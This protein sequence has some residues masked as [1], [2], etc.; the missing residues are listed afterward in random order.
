MGRHV[1]KGG[2][3]CKCLFY[4]GGAIRT[5]RSEPVLITYDRAK[6]SLSKQRDQ[7]QCGTLWFGRGLLKL[8]LLSL[9]MR[10]ELLLQPTKPTISQSLSLRDSHGSLFYLDPTLIAELRD[11]V[12]LVLSRDFGGIMT[13]MHLWRSSPSSS[14]SDSICPMVIP[15]ANSNLGHKHESNNDWL[16]H[17]AV[18]QLAIKF[19]YL[20]F[21]YFCVPKKIFF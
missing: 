3:N 8:P 14:F 18:W 1:L 17:G 11:C 9:Y 19:V 5:G 13:F 7:C 6:Q 4:H 16:I 2:N 21:Q 15:I 12:W 10:T 20:R